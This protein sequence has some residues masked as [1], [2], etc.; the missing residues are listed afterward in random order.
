MTNS[1]L[2]IINEINL[3]NGSNYK[4][5]VLEKH[6][7]NELFKRV[8]KM[9]LDKVSFTY[10]VSMKNVEKFAPDKYKGTIHL[11]SALDIL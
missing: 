4:K 5:T 7:D 9:A 11:H 3:E 10:G 1:I 2:D 8:L 6:K